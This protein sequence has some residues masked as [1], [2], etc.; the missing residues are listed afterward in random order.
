MLL[1]AQ[2]P[3][4]RAGFYYRIDVVRGDVVFTHHRQLKDA[5]NHVRQAVKEPHQRTK[6]VQ[7]EAHRV[8]DTQSHSFWRNH[9]DAFRGQVCKEDEQAGYQ[10]E[11]EDK[12]ELFGQFNGHVLNK[13]TIKRRGKRRITHDTAENGDRVEANLHHGEEH[14]GVF[15]HFQDAGGIDVAFIGKQLQFDF[16]GRGQRDLRYREKRADGNQTKYY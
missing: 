12:A 5:E 2:H 8:D 3:G 6:H 1:L 9:T 13:Q 11:G 7:T 10:R 14:P 4:Q 15:L 16:T